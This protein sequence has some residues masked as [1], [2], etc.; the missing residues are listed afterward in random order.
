MA[1]AI[2]MARHLNSDST[3]AIFVSTLIQVRSVSEANKTVCFPSS[4]ELQ[5]FIV[6]KGKG[7]SGPA[8]RKETAALYCANP[9]QSEDK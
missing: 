5:R 4:T 6:S 9:Q 2:A 8:N 1:K 7:R 3:R